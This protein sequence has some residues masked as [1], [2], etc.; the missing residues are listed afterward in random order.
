MKNKRRASYQARKKEFLVNDYFSRMKEECFWLIVS[1]L[2]NE[3]IL[4]LAS[5]SSQTRKRLS[6]MF[7]YTMTLPASED[8]L[9][10]FKSSPYNQNKAILRLKMNNPS[11][12]GSI[13]Y[14]LL[15]MNL[16]R[17]SQV[18]LQFLDD[19]DDNVRKFRLAIL[20]V[21][22]ILVDF[23]NV[24]QLHLSVYSSFFINFSPQV[25]GSKLMSGFKHVQNLFLT[26]TENRR[27]SDA[28][29]INHNFQN[30]LSLLRVEE[31]KINFESTQNPLAIAK[32]E[33]KFIARLA[34]DSSKFTPYLDLHNLQKLFMNYKFNNSSYS[35][36]LQQC[37]S[38]CPNLQTIDA[39]SVQGFVEK[40]NE[41]SPS[42]FKKTTKKCLR[43]E[44]IISAAH[45]ISDIVKPIENKTKV[46][47][48]SKSFKM[49]K[50]KP[51]GTTKIDKS[52]KA[53][54]V[55]RKREL[56]KKDIITSKKKVNA[57]KYDRKQ[58]LKRK[59][60]GVTAKKIKD[61]SKK[62]I[63]DR[64][65]KEEPKKTRRLR[66]GTCDGCLATNC[67]KCKFCL[68]MTQFGGKSTLRR[69]CISRICNNYKDIGGKK[70]VAKKDIVGKNKKT[71]K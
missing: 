35:V 15:R 18:S 56:L 69:P 34:F 5:V 52:L 39:L 65:L 59:V 37:L 44:V 11:P 49:E 16:S 20:A 57:V 33:N 30:F 43:E 62:L 3:D 54:T 71:A 31:L 10:S 2:E 8:F 27:D 47:K 17:V 28:I 29:I 42:V 14:W 50:S 7:I 12:D 45:D 68:D 66:C 24:K 67:G 48:P 64:R 60:T 21:L 1:Y 19:P 26:I 23:K 61:K 46:M 38:S 70:K 22:Q 32:I 9:T 53:G 63:A 51:L 40:L 36:S 6:S 25:F 58:K 55:K 4:S 41:N 13:S